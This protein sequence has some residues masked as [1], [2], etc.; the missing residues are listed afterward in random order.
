MYHIKGLVIVNT[1]HDFYYKQHLHYGTVKRELVKYVQLFIEWFL[2]YK[3]IVIEDN[4]MCLM[5]EEANLV[6]FPD[7]GFSES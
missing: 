5:L 7:E 4:M 6:S 1:D 3:V 2:E